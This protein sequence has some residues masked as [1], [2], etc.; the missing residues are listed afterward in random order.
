MAAETPSR[1]GGPEV[2]GELLRDAQP[3]SRRTAGRVAADLAA[4]GA[5]EGDRLPGE[6]VLAQRYG[7]SRV[8]ARA[9][10]S[11]LA[12]RRV[13]AATP[14]RGWYVVAPP[15]SVDRGQVPVGSRP[16]A[17]EP[18]RVRVRGHADVQG[19]AD[20]A[21]SQGLVAR[22]RV[23]EQ[24]VRA[25][26]VDEGA[27]LRLAPGSALFELRRLRFLDGLVVVD[28]HNLVPAALHPGL[29]DVDF[30]T[31]GL[32]ATLRAARPPVHPRVADYAVEARAATAREATL[33]EIDGHVPLL[34][35]RQLSFDETGRPVELTTAA[36][37][38]DRYRF[39]ASITSA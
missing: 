12:E 38:G 19:F 37:R 25:A 11:L 36:Y 33:L 14:S 35:A 22:A 8:T 10:L 1:A 4:A 5:R 39:T 18:S 6:R 3:L 26:T 27:A 30:S 24:R 23:L 2:A 31:A 21:A 17:S 29:V 34:V 7:V 28:E 16:G 20:Q 32:Y 13:V 15:R 9:A